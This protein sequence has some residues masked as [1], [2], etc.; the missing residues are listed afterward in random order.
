MATCNWLPSAFMYLVRT[1]TLLR[2]H[3]LCACLFLLVDLFV[4]F[5]WNFVWIACYLKAFHKSLL[6]KAQY[7]ISLVQ[8]RSRHWRRIIGFHVTLDVQKYE[9]VAF[10]CMHMHDKVLKSI[11]L[12][13][14][15]TLFWH[16]SDIKT[17]CIQYKRQ[18]YNSVYFK[19]FFFR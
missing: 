9:L 10:Q 13:V 12:L 4:Q 11:T 2:C 6:H 16:H 5:Y 1:R 14:A 8:G 17:L 3:Y 7:D 19:P 15:L 18:N